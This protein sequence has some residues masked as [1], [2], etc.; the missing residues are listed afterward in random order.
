MVFCSGSDAHMLADPP[1]DSLALLV[2]GV[3]TGN[4]DDFRELYR[5]T[6][7]LVYAR[8]RALIPDRHEADDLLQEV[9][10]KIWQASSAFDPR[11]ARAI[12][13][14]VAIARHATLNRLR[15]AS[16]RGHAL[17]R[18][19]ELGEEIADG[20]ATA[21][22]A[23]IR[24]QTSEAISAR[25]R[26]LRPHYRNVVERAYL[27]GQSYAQISEA[28]GVP[29]NTLK[30]WIRRAIIDIRDGLD[31]DARGAGGIIV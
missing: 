28:T 27:R 29:V 20:R 21:E 16:Y 25:I 5:R 22:G 8:I 15:S 23:Y 18:P 13:W 3:A 17:S 31:G 12:T 19:I 1:S 4:R 11:R 10:F 6:R 7:K 2:Q 9:F 30:T 26:G 24:T 14:I